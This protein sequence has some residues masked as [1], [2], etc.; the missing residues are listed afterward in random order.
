MEKSINITLIV[1][2]TLIL[3]AL[4]GVYTAFQLSPN[5]QTNIIT[6][7]GMAE[8]SA[9]PDKVGLYFNVETK[10]NDSKTAHA[11]NSE[12]TDAVITA[13]V[14]QGFERKD[15]QT[16]NYQI[17]E[18]FDWSYGKQ[19]SKGWKAVQSI[20]VKMSTVQTDQIGKAI[21]AGINAGATLSYIN[22]ELSQELENQYKANAIK[23]ASEDAKL[24][25]EAMVSGQGKSLGKLVSMTDSSFNYNPWRV[26]DYAVGASATEN[27]AM[28]KSATSIQPSEQTITAQVSVSYKIN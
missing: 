17:Y 11:A 18:D 25:A 15:I 7:D 9:A 8:I 13:L 22:F 2:G 20:V 23:L 26:Y 27:V 16:Q 10:G 4:I 19:T 6:A 28:A 3:L 5:A 12:V 1:A 21:D 24:K 14:K